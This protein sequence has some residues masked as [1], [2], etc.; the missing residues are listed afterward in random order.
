MKYLLYNIHNMSI[1]IISCTKKYIYRQENIYGHTNA[2]AYA[3]TRPLRI[4]IHTYI[5][6]DTN[7]YARTSKYPCTCMYMRFY[8]CLCK[9]VYAHAFICMHIYAY[10]SIHVYMHGETETDRHVY[11]YDTYI[12]IV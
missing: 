2:T 1:T 8:A 5:H 12:H 7:A 6:P 4:Y 9:H 11:T 10:A 3:R